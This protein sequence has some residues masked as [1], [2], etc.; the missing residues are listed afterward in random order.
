MPIVGTRC[1]CS[2]RAR[3]VTTLAGILAVALLLGFGALLLAADRAAAATT[4]IGAVAEIRAGELPASI[5]EGGYTVQISEASGT[6]AV[7]PGYDRIT[8]W[9]HSAGTLAGELTFRVYRP[10]GALREF[11]VVGSDTRVVSA[12]AVHTFPV[13]IPVQAGDRIGL[14]SEQVQIAYETFNVGDR[15]GF[16]GGDHPT[17]SIDTTDGDPFP[18]FKLD[19]S[20][21]LATPA[22]P[23]VPPVAVTNPATGAAAAYPLPAPRLQRLRMAPSRF[24]AARNGATTRRTPRRRMGTRV[25]YQVDIASSVRFRVQRVLVGRRTSRSRGARCGVSTPARRRFSTCLRYI[26][27]EGGFSQAARPGANS[28]YFMGRLSG[29][30]LKPGRYRL[31]ATATAQ[32]VVG[33]T[34]RRSFRIRR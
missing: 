18:Q 10:T 32:G 20:A 1:A 15:I 27:L 28:L 29:R 26:T 31:L 3:R 16:F 30:T 6:Y 33:N 23:P 19:V 13:R 11:I 7:P 2:L 9:S 21:T 5:S 25:S 24:A 12:G 4:E 34:V 14:S 17:A 8:A 22:N